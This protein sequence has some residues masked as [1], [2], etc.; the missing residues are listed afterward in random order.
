MSTLLFHCGP[1]DS[2]NELMLLKPILAGHTVHLNNKPVSTLTEVQMDVRAKKAAGVI[3]TSEDLLNRLLDFPKKKATLDDY[4]GSVITKNEIEYLILNP[5]SHLVTTPYGDHLYRRFLTKLTAPKDWLQ[6]PAFKWEIANESNIADLFQL[7]SSSDYIAVDIE[8]VQLNLAITCSGYCGIWIDPVSRCFTLLSIV[9]PCTSQFF[10][11]WIRKFNSLPQPKIFQNGKYD[12]LYFARYG[13][14][15]HNWLFDTA[16]LFHSW[17]SELPKRLDFITAYTLRNWVYWKSESNTSD[18]TEY[19]R[20]NAKDTF[21]TAASFIFLVN[22]IPDWARTN[23]LLEFPLVFP[24]LLAEMTGIKK[25]QA[26]FDRLKI[27]FEEATKRQRAEMEALIAPGFNPGSSQQ[28]LRL[29]HALGAK[30]LKNTTPPSKDKFGSRHP[31]NK[32]LIKKIEKYRKDNKLR[33]S[34]LKENID[35]QGRIIYSLNPHGT[36]TARLASRESAFWCG[37]QIQNIPRDK[38]DA[39]TKE[40]ISIKEIFAADPGFEFAEADYEQAETRD[41]AYIS[42]DKTLLAV[43]EDESKDFHSYNASSF[44]A[45]EYDKICK[46]VVDAD[47]KWSH[48]RIDIPLVDLAKRTNHGANYNMQERMMVDTMG[49]ERVLRAK[50]MLNLPARFTPTDVTKFLLERFASTYPGVKGDY[51]QWVKATVIATKMLTGADGWTRYCFG[52]PDGRYFN[53]LVAHCP[54]SLNARTLNTAW[55]NVFYNV[56]MPNQND[57]KLCAQ[58]HDSII[59]QYRVGRTDLVDSVGRSMVIPT[60]VKDVHGVV[61]TLVVPVAIKAGGTHWATCKKYRTFK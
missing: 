8:T 7:L 30:D 36:D 19:Y 61:R 52:K 20:Y 17:Y 48:D 55:L 59:F 39:D 60:S 4:Y 15:V 10:L 51:Y 24:C 1:Q 23:Y 44:F 21:A 2:Q 31:L 11:A 14:P 40:L 37:L 28:V 57:F 3:T 26:A 9:I 54:Q 42:G 6:L 45:V 49:I 35:L 18:I 13:S 47:G 22:Q 50:R 41:T 25:D 16:H 32:F 53:S 56:W 29:M 5:V 33:T 34:Y 43:V 27:K 38:D 58:V 12:N 46:S